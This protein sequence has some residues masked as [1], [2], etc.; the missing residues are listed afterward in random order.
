MD[1][2]TTAAWETRGATGESVRLLE[3]EYSF[4][5]RPPRH[6]RER[7]G[8]FCAAARE[9]LGY[10]A[11]ERV[12]ISSLPCSKFVPSDEAALLCSC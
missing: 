8:S 6:V 11:C 10:K 5:Q 12:D 3:T 7:R 4:A 1:I 9:F 2:R